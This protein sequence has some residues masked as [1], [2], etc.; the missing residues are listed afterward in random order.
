M[1]AIIVSLKNEY[2][3]YIDKSITHVFSIDTI[4]DLQ[5]NEAVTSLVWEAFDEDLD[6]LKVVVEND[7]VRVVSSIFA[8]VS[9][10]IETC[11]FLNTLKVITIDVHKPMIEEWCIS[12]GIHSY[13][14]LDKNSYMYSIDSTKPI[15]FSNLLWKES[16]DTVARSLQESGVKNINIA[17]TV[18]DPTW[19]S[20][21]RKYIKDIRAL[22]DRHGIRVFSINSLFYKHTANLFKDQEKGRFISHFKQLIQWAHLLGCK[23][24][25]YGSPTSKSVSYNK[26]DKY[27]IYQAAHH[28]FMEVMR[29]MGDHVQK[30]NPDM[31]IIIK[32]NVNCNYI[33][34]KQHADELVNAIDHPNIVSGTERKY[35][36][37]Q[38]D[39]FNMIEFDSVIDVSLPFISSLQKRGLL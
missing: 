1:T 36:C 39:Q 26:I 21:N 4:S 22:W 9:E 2:Y 19:K 11:C 23:Y 31:K 20:L 12:L 30:W 27:D 34:E 29:S 35:I 6:V 17:L 25:I 33:C 3:K 38:F 32:P 15:V 10:A 24:I 13:E 7:S 16:N 14:I 5:S 18:E 28:T 8:R 37:T